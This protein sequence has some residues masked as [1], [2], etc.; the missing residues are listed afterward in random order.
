MFSSKGVVYVCVCCLCAAAVGRERLAAVGATAAA[1]LS[2]SNLIGG[3]SHKVRGCTW[4]PTS[5]EVQAF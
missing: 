2:V 3:A 1:G 4:R 5:V